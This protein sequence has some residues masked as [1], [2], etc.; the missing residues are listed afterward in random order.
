MPQMTLSPDLQSCKHFLPKNRDF[1]EQPLKALWPRRW[2]ERIAFLTASGGR[3][4]SLK[5]NKL[6]IDKD[7]H[8]GYI[9]RRPD[10]QAAGVNPAL[11]DISHTDRAEVESSPQVAPNLA[12]RVIAR[13]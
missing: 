1:S 11:K 10:T 6:G 9:C 5:K 2:S 4:Y 8:S 12:I 13:R 3:L 7:I